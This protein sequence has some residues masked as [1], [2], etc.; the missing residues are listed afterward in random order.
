MAFVA[1][2]HAQGAS[3]PRTLQEALR[4]PDSVSWLK[5]VDKELKSLIDMG[6]FEFIDN[7]PKGRRAIS[8][9]LVFKI[10][11]LPDG[12][13]ERYKARLVA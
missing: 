1:T 10:K 7:L 6:T 9:K 8:S 5:A 4:G 12:T 11:R 2:V 13:I 3:E